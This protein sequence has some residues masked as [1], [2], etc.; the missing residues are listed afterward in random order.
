MQIATELHVKRVQG[1]GSILAADRI[2]GLLERD[3][4]LSDIERAIGRALLP[5]G[6]ANLDAH[7]ALLALSEGPNGQVKL[8]TTN[9][10]LLFEA[11]NRR[12]LSWSPNNL[13]DLKRSEN[14]E[15]IVH[16]H[17]KLDANYRQATG[18]RR[19]LSSAEFGRA[20]LAEGWATEFMRSAIARYR[21][22]FVGYTAD[23]PPVQYLLEALNRGK[24]ANRQELYASQ[25][26]DAAEVSALWKHKG[27]DSDEAARL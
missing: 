4:D 19:V 23:D 21:I 25:A 5:A 6:N 10:D 11:A 7:R 18:G 24:A 9:F 8:V 1:V 26:G 12:L 27:A 16:L 22:V 14:F 20:Y 3:F 13:P 15:G 2:F 17:G